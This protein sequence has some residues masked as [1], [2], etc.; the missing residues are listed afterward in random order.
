MPYSHKR[1]KQ[2]EKRRAELKEQKQASRKF[3]QD[4]QYTDRVNK[5]Q[6][7]LV[8][9]E[10]IHDNLKAN[11]QGVVMAAVPNVDRGDVLEVPNLYHLELFP[12]LS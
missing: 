9:S 2:A 12:E 3:I 7:N 4:Y 8:T 11:F 1:S 5:E 10:E 6:V